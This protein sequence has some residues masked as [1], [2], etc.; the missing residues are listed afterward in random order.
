MTGCCEADDCLEVYFNNRTNVLEASRLIQERGLAHVSLREVPPQDWNK[1][2]RD[3]AEAV[4]L[5][6]N[7]WTG[8]PWKQP[9]G[10]DWLPIEPQMAFGTGHHLSTRLAA[11]A[12][13]QQR[14]LKGK[15]SKRW[16][17]LDVGA[18]SGILCLLAAKLGASQSW[19]LEQDMECC[20]NLLVNGHHNPDLHKH[21]RFLMGSCDSL[22]NRPHWDVISINMIR[23]RSQ[24]LLPQCHRWLNPGGLCIW[25]GILREEGPLI[26]KELNGGRWRVLETFVEEEWW[27]GVLERAG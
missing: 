16:R 22:K 15:Q 25:S 21:C 27:C 10:V 11:R 4:A 18:G 3:A 13:E 1:T 7:I 12:M 23:T 6:P 17:F 9:P 8:P 24:P 26:E 19:G 5:T 2:W 20:E 14:R